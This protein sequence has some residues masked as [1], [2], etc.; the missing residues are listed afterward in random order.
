MSASSL[1]SC[2]AQAC[3]CA[4]GPC[5]EPASLTPPRNR[6]G[7]GRI[8]TRLGT[9]GSFLTAAVDA[10]SS[11]D[12]PVLRTLGTRDP[13]DPVMALLDGWAAV[14]DVLTF[15]RDTYAN[16]FYRRT[17]RRERSLRYLAA[18]VGYRPRPG[19]AA[20][21]PIAYLLDP[22]A[23][24]LT[25]PSAARVQSVPKPGEQM[26]AFETGRPLDARAEWSEMR[27][28]Q[29][30]IPAL[31]RID[32]LL[33]TEIRLAGT[34]TQAR[35]GERLLFVF[36]DKP[37]WQVA[38]EVA[39]TRIDVDANCVV[40]TLKPRPGLT[41]PLGLKLLDIL[42]MSVERLAAAVNNTKAF[43]A[44]SALTSYVLGASARDI[45]LWEAGLI[46]EVR[47]LMLEI[48]Q[49]ARRDGRRFEPD[50]GG[51]LSLV[52][53]EPAA[54]FRQPPVSLADQ[55]GAMS[56]MRT[57]LLS[58]VSGAAGDT[59]YA[60]M[61]NFPPTRKRD[62]EHP[63]LYLMRLSTGAF[64][65]S[66][67]ATV[68]VSD[69]APKDVDLANDDRADAFLDVLGEGVES[70]GYALIDG[71]FRMKN[72]DRPV[73]LVRIAHVDDVQTVARSDY[74]LSAK[75]T[76]LQVSAL[77]GEKD[78]PLL[79]QPELKLRGLQAT[80]YTVQ[81][82]QVELAPE[83][84]GTPV[85]GDRIMLDGLYPEFE[86]GR[87]I[88]VAG[89]R[90]DIFAGD[91]PVEGV[92]DGELATVAGVEQTLLEGSASDTPHTSLL[93]TTS[94]AHAYK[95]TRTTIYGN[96]VEATHGESVSETLG[97]GDS[98]Q[99]FQ[100]FRLRRA[101]LTF[102]SAPTTSGIVDALEVRV[103]GLK[104]GETDFLADAGP[105]DRV[106]QT[107]LASDGSATIEF[108]DGKTGVRLPTAAENVKA[109]YRVGIGRPGN[110]AA[111]QISLAT[112]RPLGVQSVINPLKAV[113]GA[114]PDGPETIRR[115][116]PVPTLAL[117]P[118]ARLVSVA[119][120][121]HFARAFAGIGDVR[122]ALL[123][124][125]RYQCVHVTVAG[126][127]DAPL[128]PEEAPV[129]SLVAAY[130][131]FGDPALPVIVEVR[132]RISL[133]IQASIRLTGDADRVDVEAALRA[134]LADAFSFAP[135]GLVRPAYRS[136]LI[137]VLQT[138]PG[139][140]YVDL[141]VFGG[142]SDLDLL[143]A[144]RF[145]ETIH[146]LRKQSEEGRPLALVPVL[147]ARVAAADDPSNPLGTRGILPGQTAYL[148]ADVPET[149]ALNWL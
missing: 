68:P 143:D 7:L 105:D 1:C 100:R 15:Y 98:S 50:F 19:V 108:G 141:D 54:A 138:T 45:A 90:A 147:P 69:G 76:R 86:P 106:F 32:A 18:Q 136:E 87:Q 26:Q 39:A 131:Q 92:R 101:P 148:R 144:D 67:P 77:S 130:A 74:G 61:R 10:L 139:I 65:T 60:A 123:A 96:V 24:P 89:E 70:G 133:L 59:L 126:V 25:V 33:R 38:R 117:F 84:L 8:S 80:F 21:V 142:I 41:Q 12:F 82:E 137:A 4:C 5:Q 47:E 125:G 149:L 88:V 113:G 35:P 129:T 30:W 51:L 128:D 119:D 49:P 55:T 64:G 44:V 104:F 103:N 102:V 85:E 140:V 28:R 94:L 72:T 95:R 81:S 134:R 99:R 53:R 43:L 48:S 63:R 93:L 29:S 122:A 83:P 132:D 37:G 3:D 20:S 6:P 116:I 34:S 42:D 112:T 118:N 57:A 9:H 73:R 145:A 79:V 11:A 120:Y 62:A 75:V 27:P 52:A 109:I 121:E 56:R 66:A 97:S 114:D 135:R 36:S 71:P 127:D 46:A 107:S 124:D 13:G 78:A 22:N 146:R 58:S 91:L 40:L 17:A 14:A 110:V 111:E 2:G 115:N 31:R 16:E 23:H